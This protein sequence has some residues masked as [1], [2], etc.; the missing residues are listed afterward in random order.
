MPQLDI[1]TYN[2]TSSFL[3]VSFWTYFA[4]LYIAVSYTSQKISAAYYF[5]F[6]TILISILLVYA[7]E[8]SSSNNNNNLNNILI[9]K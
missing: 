8:V 4:A 3:L 9:K 2:I 7:L 5:K 1:V 6:Y